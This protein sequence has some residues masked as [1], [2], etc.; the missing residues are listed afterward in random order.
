M[1]QIKIGDPIWHPCSMDI[2]E[3]KVVGIATYEHFT[4]YLLKAKHAVGACGKIEVIIS[5]NNG[6]LRFVELINED[7]IEHAS[8]LGDFVEG[9]YYNVENDAKLSFYNQQITLYKSSRDRKKRE[10]DIA[11]NHLN[12]V[13]LLVKHLKS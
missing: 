4:H 12:R 1:K 11:Q 8:G 2:L 9:K 6:V 5:E 13:E 3:H 10:L 7:Q